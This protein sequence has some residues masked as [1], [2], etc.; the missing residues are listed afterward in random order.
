MMR[1][2]GPVFLLCSGPQSSG[3]I[4]GASSAGRRSGAANPAGRSGL[5][6]LVQAGHFFAGAA[7]GSFLAMAAKR[8]RRVAI[9][10]HLRRISTE[11]VVV[12]T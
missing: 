4:V 12:L 8:V 7:G 5:R 2:F 6:A 3:R 11:A 1:C 9:S 10:H